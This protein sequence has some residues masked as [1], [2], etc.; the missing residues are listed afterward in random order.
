M[1]LQ[2]VPGERLLHDPAME[3]VLLEFEQQQTAPEERADEVV[4][5]LTEIAAAPAEHLVDRIGSADQH[6]IDTEGA[7]E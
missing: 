3:H 7:V 1:G 5:P 6:P 2:P 4:P